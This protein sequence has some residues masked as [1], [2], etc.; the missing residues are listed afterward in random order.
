[1]AALAALCRQVVATFHAVGAAVL[2]LSANQWI[3]LSHS[4]AEDANRVPDTEERLV[5]QSAVEAGEPRSLG[6]TGL[7]SRRRPRIIPS[8]FGGSTQTRLRSVT[9]LPL[10]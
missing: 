5:A 2:G 8:P 4:G 10:S 6:Q 1:Q 7:V 3:V 9:F